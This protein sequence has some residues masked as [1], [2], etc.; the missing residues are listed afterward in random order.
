ME[1]RLILRRW[2]V[3]SCCLWVCKKDVWGRTER[4]NRSSNRLDF[5]A[6]SHI[7]LSL[8]HQTQPPKLMGREGNFFR[9]HKVWGDPSA[10][11]HVGLV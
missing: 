2:G 4:T 7:K 5:G 6:T 10:D 1:Q 11:I 8:T 9:T 3:Q